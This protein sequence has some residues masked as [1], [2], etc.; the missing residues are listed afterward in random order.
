MPYPVTYF[1]IKFGSKDY[2]EENFLRFCI[3]TYSWQQII[4]SSTTILLQQASY[5]ANKLTD[6]PTVSM[7]PGGHKLQIAIVIQVVKICLLTWNKKVHHYFRKSL[8]MG[9]ILSRFNSSHTST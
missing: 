9:Y 3:L 2:S 5:V 1:K 7:L 8:K 6:I 4:P